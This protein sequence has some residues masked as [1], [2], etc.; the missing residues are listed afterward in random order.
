MFGR[1]SLRRSPGGGLPELSADPSAWGPDRAAGS[2]P[3]QPA[4]SSA[5]TGIR[6][7]RIGIT[8]HLVRSL[9]QSGASP[10]RRRYTMPALHRREFAALDSEE[11]ENRDSDL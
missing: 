2:P 1:V 4:A 11:K 6:N 5:T 9:P 3:V 10:P 8:L 7:H